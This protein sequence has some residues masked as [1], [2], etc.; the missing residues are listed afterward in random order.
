MNQVSKI[1]DA[2][3][4]A[5]PKRVILVMLLFFASLASNIPSIE[6]DTSTEAF[7]SKKDKTRID[8]NRFREQFGRDEIVL[9]LIHPKNVFDLEFLEN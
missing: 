6:V 3:F 7:F 4:P 8:Y 5:H 1:W 2:G 9:A